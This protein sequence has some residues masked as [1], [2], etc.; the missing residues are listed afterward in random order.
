M[1][2]EPRPKQEQDPLS[3]PS[4]DSNFIVNPPF[5]GGA[6]AS[7]KR[8]EEADWA[9]LEAFAGRETFVCHCRRSEHRQ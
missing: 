8:L 5:R 3:K 9:K 7:N 6:F 2:I 4:D 1:K